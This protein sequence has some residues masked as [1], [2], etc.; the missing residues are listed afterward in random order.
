MPAESLLSRP[1]VLIGLPS[2]YKRMLP[3]HLINPKIDQIRSFGT[4]LE[5][6]YI[7]GA[8]ALDQ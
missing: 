6:R 2:T 1:A 8:G 3:Y 7:F 4:V 5:P